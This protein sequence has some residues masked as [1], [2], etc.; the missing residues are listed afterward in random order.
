MRAIADSV[1][2]YLHG[3]ISHISG[4][5]SAGL[6]DSNPFEYCDTVMTTTHKTLQGPR[7]AIIYYRKGKRSYLEGKK[8]I[9]VDYSSLEQRI[10][11]AVFP[12]FQ[13][14]PHNHTITS[15]AVAL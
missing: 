5:V 2:A 10:Q 11:D 9:D 3:D 15:I 6:A 14:G 12:G 4:L 7:G 8:S 13:G 1:G